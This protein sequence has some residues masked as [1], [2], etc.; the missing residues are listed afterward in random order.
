ME[1]IKTFLKEIDT[2]GKRFNTKILQILKSNRDLS[3]VELAQLVS[4][5]DFFQEVQSLGYKTSADKLLKTYDKQL[6]DIVRLAKS[7][8]VNVGRIDLGLFDDVARLDTRYILRRAADFSDNYKSELIKGL[9]GTNT[10][11]QLINNVLPIIQ[12]AVP[13]RPNW[14]EAVITQSYT[15]FS[16]T[17]TAEIFADEPNT[18]FKLIHPLD[19]RTRGLCQHAIEVQEQNPQGFTI[20]EIN[21]NILGE[22][23][24]PKYPSDNTLFTFQNLGGF[25]CRGFW[26]II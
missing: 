24:E 7:R 2:V 15:S 17:A 23:Y 14:F 20:E 9:V 16:N 26:D 1:Q 8:N 19:G 22:G 21:N 5:I 3:N 10:R 6:S 4:Q 13:F 12:E 18:K 11:E 25:N